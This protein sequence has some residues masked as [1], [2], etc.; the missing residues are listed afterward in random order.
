[1][2]R[3]VINKNICIMTDS[4]KFTHYNMYPHD[5][6]K[7][8]SYFESREGAKYP[9][10]VFFGLQYLLKEYFIGRVVDFEYIRKA[11]ALVN[12][13]FVM[14]IFNRDMWTY[15]VN[16]HQGRLPLRIRAVP[17]GMPVPIRNVMMTVENTDDKCP[18]LTN[19]CETILTHIWSAS[20]VATASRECKVMMKKYLQETSDD[21]SCLDFM[22]HDFGYRGVS[23]PEA[24]AFCGAGHLL[25]FLGTDTFG[26]I[27]LVMQYYGPIPMPAFSV[28]ATE[29]SIMT[30]LGKDGEA[31]IM[32]KILGDNPD[33]IL[34]WVIDSYDY[35]EFIRIAGTKFKERILARNG[36]LVFR[37][38]S[39]DPVKTSLDVVTMLSEYFGYSVNQKGY[40]VLN[41][42]IGMLWGDGIDFEGIK[43]ILEEFKNSGFSASNI[44]F[45]MGGGL[46]QKINRDTQMNSFKCSY[47]ERDGKGYDVSKSP[48]GSSF[49]QSKKG[50]LKLVNGE[51]GLKT[52]DEK[53]SGEDLLEDVFVNGKL[54]R[55]HLFSDIRENAKL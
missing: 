15:I 19:F 23:C 36:K 14:K 34:A 48:I 37:P 20:T 3:P 28:R 30:S 7:I 24:G 47:I 49:K 6:T 12:S 11:E 46:L 29:H 42:K 39:G 54:V 13:H 32:E 21:L 31:L 40:K 22:L 4:Y 1:M 5:T 43:N 2:E 51:C 9:Y 41:P 17:E 8:Y 16:K 26:A 38:D 50:K 27:D 53:E 33:G 45:G 55:N 18:S 10:T 44:V 35:R 25:N 52:V